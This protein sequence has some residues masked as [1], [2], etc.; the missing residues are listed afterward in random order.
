LHFIRFAPTKGVERK[1]THTKPKT[2]NETP[3][4]KAG[5]SAI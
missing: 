3:T 1:M 2:Q 5:A 4:I